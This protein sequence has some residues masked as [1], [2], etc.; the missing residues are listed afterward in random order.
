MP[1]AE[2]LHYHTIM[3]WRNRPLDIRP[4]LGQFLQNKISWTILSAWI[5]LSLGYYIS[6]ENIHREHSI[7]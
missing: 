7:D 5:L 4:L 2:Q 1:L 3:P 6:G